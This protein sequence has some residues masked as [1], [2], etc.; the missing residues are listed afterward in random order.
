MELLYE[1][2]TIC[3]KDTLTIYVDGGTFCETCG[4]EREQ[5][6]KENKNE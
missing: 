4:T 3:E 5:A 1:N 6:E 2:C